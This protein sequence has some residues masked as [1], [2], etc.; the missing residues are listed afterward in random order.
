MDHLLPDT[1]LL[2][3]TTDFRDEVL[4]SPDQRDTIIARADLILQNTIRTWGNSVITFGKDVD[5][6]RDMGQSG[7][8]GFHY[9]IWSRPLLMASVLTGDEKY[10]VKFDQLFN[11]W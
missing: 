5:F 1:D 3:S 10:L 7:K 2:E 6:N 8:Y 4:Q 11:A 9:W